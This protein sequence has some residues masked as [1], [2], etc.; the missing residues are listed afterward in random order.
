[1]IPAGN[2]GGL[3]VRATSLNLLSVL[4]T[5]V[6]RGRWL[7]AGTA[8]EP[9]AVLG[10]AAAA[11]AG[12][13]PGPPRSADLAGRP[14][15][16]RRGHPA[17]LAAGAR[18]RQQ[19]PDRLPGRPA[20]PRLRQHGPRRAA[21]RPA[22]LDLRAR[23]HRPRGGGAVAARADRQPRGAERGE[24]QPA[25]RRAHRPGRR[26]GG[27]RQPLPRARGGGPDRGRRRRRQHHDHLGAGTPLGDRPAS[28]PRRDEGPDPDAVPRA[29]RSCS[30]SSAASS[31]CWP[32][33]RR[34]PCTPAR[35]AGPS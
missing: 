5:G 22:E 28:R 26:G 12:H 14:V 4:G 30:P 6:A 3:Q 21:G 19:R 34:R 11:A 17:A 20:V 18:H 25:V 23:R 7:N 13:R 1:M 8:R 31:A 29:S 9:V 15:V 33:P 32:G 10:S 35:R 24:R 27:V 2:T 16:Q